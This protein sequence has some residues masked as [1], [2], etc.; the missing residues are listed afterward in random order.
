[1]PIATRA[2]SSKSADTSFD[3]QKNPVYVS[4]AYDPTGKWDAQSKPPVGTSLGLYAKEPGVPAP[5]SIGPGKTAKI[6]V[7]L[8]DSFKQS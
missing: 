5:I 6:S 4:V 3:V 2:V 8:D 7:T 1:M